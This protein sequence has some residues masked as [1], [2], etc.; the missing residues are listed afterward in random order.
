MSRNLIT[1]EVLP[2]M[3][4]KSL[5]NSLCWFKVDISL[6]L[7]LTLLTPAREGCVCDGLGFLHSY[8]KE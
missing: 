5:G 4:M 1:G 7:T 8:I 6:D 2:E 3:S